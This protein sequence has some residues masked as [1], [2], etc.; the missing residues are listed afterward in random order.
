MINEFGGVI[1]TDALANRPPE[2]W[3]LQ[4]ETAWTPSE[5][6]SADDGEWFVTLPTTHVARQYSQVARFW[7]F[8][9]PALPALQMRAETLMLLPRGP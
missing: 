2:E 1:F 7:R 4:R 8:L 9:W 5:G 3:E 6:I